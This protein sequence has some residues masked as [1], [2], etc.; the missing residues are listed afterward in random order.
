MKSISGKAFAKILEYHGWNLLRIKG[1]NKL[2]SLYKYTYSTGNN[3][4]SGG[5]SNG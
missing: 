1:S 2:L 4:K 3:F 5:S